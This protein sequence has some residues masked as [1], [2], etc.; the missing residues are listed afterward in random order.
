[1]EL[2]RKMYQAILE[3]V[4]APRCVQISGGEP[5]LREDIFDIIKLGK[6]MGIEH[7]ELNT[8]AIKIGTE[9]TYAKRLKEAGVDALYLSFDG[10][11]RGVIKTISNEDILDVKLKAVENCKRAGLGIILVTRLIKDV[12]FNQI[13]PI[14]EFAKRNA[15][16][17][18]AVHFQP[19]SHFGRHRGE[20]DEEHKITLT[21]VLRG[22]EEQTKGE[23]TVDNFT[24]TS[25]A[26]VHC[27]AKSLSII[28]EDNK[29]FPITRAD[30]KVW[31]KKIWI[32][33]PKLERLQGTCG[34]KKRQ[35]QKKTN[36]RVHAIVVPGRNFLTEVK[37]II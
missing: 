17:V 33:R 10:I 29:L 8:N 1:M 5:T 6:E 37:H 25:C 12:N 36:A 20:D 19:V 34:L 13:G 18:K 21:D 14:I 31:P 4:R 26:N 2:I 27:D 16:T 22:V 24:P 30:G 23:L 3:K 15:P 9:E 11:D 32:F 7:I 35:K 28:L